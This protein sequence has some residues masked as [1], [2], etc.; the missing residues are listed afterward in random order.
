MK[1]LL[2]FY[3]ISD[4]ISKSLNEFSSGEINSPQDVMRIYNQ[5][6]QYIL[7]IIGGC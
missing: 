2:S 6:R 4:I 7:S 3:G 1:G 5:V